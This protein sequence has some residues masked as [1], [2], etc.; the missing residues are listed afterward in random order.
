MV[1][2]KYKRS[3]I[4]VHYVYRSRCQVILLRFCYLWE[5]PFTITARL[6]KSNCSVGDFCIWLR[7]F[8]SH[9]QLLCISASKNDLRF[10]TTITDQRFHLKPWNFI[11]STTT[12]ECSN[13]IQLAHLPGSFPRHPAAT[14]LLCGLSPFQMMLRVLIL[15]YCTPGISLSDSLL[16]ARNPASRVNHRN[17]ETEQL[18]WLQV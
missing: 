15:T 9:R 16:L 7:S 4:V 10:C 1:F 18:F 6:E 12:I 11:H 17:G 14:W 3:G 2:T 8:I 13:Q 5:I